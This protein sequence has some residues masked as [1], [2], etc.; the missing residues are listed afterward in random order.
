VFIVGKLVSFV[1]DRNLYYVR[2]AATAL[3]D[4]S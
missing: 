1:P 2:L 3:R 4:Q